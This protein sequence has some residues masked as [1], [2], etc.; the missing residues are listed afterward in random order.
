LNLEQKFEFQIYITVRNQSK[1]VKSLTIIWLCQM[2]R[3]KVMLL[4]TLF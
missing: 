3:F 1:L 4:L 2:I